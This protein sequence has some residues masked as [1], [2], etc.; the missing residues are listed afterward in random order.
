[1]AGKRKS[2]KR[3]TICVVIPAFNEEGTVFQVVRA[4]KK[5]S[6]QVI[7]V[8]DA[9]SDSTAFEA[10]RA[11][12]IVLHHIVNLGQGAA[13]QTGFEYVKANF[14]LAIVVTFDADNQFVPSEISRIV[15]PIVSK[16]YQVVL[17]SRF[18]GRTI[19]MPFLRKVILK[20]GILFTWF[21]TGTK[22]TDTHNG[23]RAFSSQ[24]IQQIS[25][26]QNRMA[27]ASELIDQ[28]IGQQLSFIE[29]PVT[30]RYHKDR[31][32]QSNVGSFQ[33]FKDILFEKFS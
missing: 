24:A 21:M 18:L 12:A 26:R 13:L 29:I 4:V 17:G 22:L 5:F 14:P 16:K 25:I 9:S 20:I 6:N 3:P 30:V 7:V 8:N 11:G 15:R 1:M 31:L 33:I 19:E 23:F 27:H 10:K 32:G 28:I 2:L